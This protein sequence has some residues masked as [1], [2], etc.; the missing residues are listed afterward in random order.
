MGA[1]CTQC[2]MPEVRAGC[3]SRR[4]AQR[5]QLAIGHHHLDGIHDVLN[6]AVCG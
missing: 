1:F 4:L 5:H 2:Q 6:I 3:G